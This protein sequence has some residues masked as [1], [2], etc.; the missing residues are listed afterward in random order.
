MDDNT[1]NNLK[2]ALKFSPDNIPLKSHLAESL[3]NMDR[4]IE[5]EQ[6]YKELLALQDTIAI[7]YGLAQVY[8]K[9][10]QYSTCS[11]LLEDSLKNEPN[12]INLLVLYS[13][14]L[15]RENLIDQAQEYYSKVLALIPGYKDEE[16]DTE[17]R[18]NAIPHKYEQDESHSQL[19]DKPK[20]NFGDVGGMEHIKKEID[21]KIIQPLNHADLYKAYGK[22]TGG[23]ILL[24]GPPGCGK[25]Y[26]AKATAGE[27]NANFINVSLNDIL[28][29][30]IGNSE[31]NL[32]EILEVARANKPCVLFFDEIDALGASRNDMKNSSSRHLINQ[33]LQELDGI[34]SDNDGILVLGATNAP[35]HLDTAFRRPGR[36]DRIIFIPPPDEGARESIL[37]IKLKGK[38]TSTINYKKLA[39]LATDYSGAD[40]EAAIDIAIEEKLETSFKTGVPQPIEEKDLA[41]AMKKHNASTKEWFVSA[42]NFALY[43]NESGLYNDVLSY[44]KIKK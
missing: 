20:L 5:A 28:D 1:I 30:W 18:V 6:E 32:H 35:W 16:L 36:F 13:K 26:I 15:L 8:F 3:L 40:I 7:R 4:L 33:F 43:A 11:V 31:K 22:K 23:G 25:T 29:M 9:Q 39:K 37:Q 2:E 38:P 44:L 24:Y 27:I 10:E 42:K 14:T 17:L 19:L 34:E 41:K 21:L 12:N